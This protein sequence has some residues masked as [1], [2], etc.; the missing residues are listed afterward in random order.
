MCI[1]D[2]YIYRDIFFQ[3][4]NRYVLCVLWKFERVSRCNRII[5]RLSIH[6]H[7]IL[8]TS[9]LI[10]PC[11]SISFGSTYLVAFCRYI[12]HNLYFSLEFLFRLDRWDKCKNWKWLEKEKAQ[13]RT[14]F[15]PTNL[16]FGPICSQVSFNRLD[17]F[18][19]RGRKKEKKN[20]KKVCRL[21]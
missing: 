6:A 3:S 14:N 4:T 13:D 17:L 20:R 16:P 19:Y 1:R 12:N 5:L 9:D 15:L 11:S 8:N 2:R 18:D 21:L 10:P 7:E